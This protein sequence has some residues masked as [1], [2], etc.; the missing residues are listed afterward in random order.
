MKL[1]YQYMI[2]FFNFKTTSSQLHPLQVENSESNSRLVVD[3]ADYGK[4]RLERVKNFNFH[5]PEVVMSRYHDPQFQ[6]GENYS[7]V[8]SRDQ[9]I[10]NFAV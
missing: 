6:V 8:L 4:L 7:Y 1:V 5:P 9:Q 10:E 3:E 2:I